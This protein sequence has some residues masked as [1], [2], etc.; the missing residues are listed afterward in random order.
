MADRIRI[1]TDRLG[2]DAGRIYGCILNLAKEMEGMKQ[3]AAAL[4]RMWEGAGKDAF[5]K[6]F[7]ADIEAAQEAVSGLKEVHSYDTNAK[8]RYEQCERK[9][10]SMIADI[11]V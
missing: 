2:M 9:I 4:E 11:R 6:S 7:M 5:H 8:S 1:N 10:A 3:S